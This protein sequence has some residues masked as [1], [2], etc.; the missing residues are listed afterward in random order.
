MTNWPYTIELLVEQPKDRS[1]VRVVAFD[2]E[3][4]TGAKCIRDIIEIKYSHRSGSTALNYLHLA[5]DEDDL[6]FAQL[7]QIDKGRAKRHSTVLQKII[8]HVMA[9]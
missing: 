3:N 9:A 1:N 6:V 8:D 2:C 5:E 4:S 7:S